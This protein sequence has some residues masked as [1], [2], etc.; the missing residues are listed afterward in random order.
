MLHRTLLFLGMVLLWAAYKHQQ[1]NHLLGVQ[2][3]APK[4]I[5]NPT[6]EGLE[7]ITNTDLSSLLKVKALVETGSIHSRNRFGSTPLLLAAC[8]NGD[9][10]V[11]EFLYARGARLHDRDVYGNTALMC[12][13]ENGNL[14]LVSWLLDKG[15]VVNQRNRLG[16]T[17]LHFAAREGKYQTVKALLDKGAK[18]LMKDYMGRSPQSAAMKNRHVRVAKLLGPRVNNLKSGPTVLGHHFVSRTH[19][20]TVAHR[21]NAITRKPMSK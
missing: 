16:Q 5:A 1:L 10:E 7:G 2:A 6:A 13:A 12:A 18:R 4:E 11:V 9:P 21:T 15:V 14:R 17:A 3:S 20:T 8:Q 19:N